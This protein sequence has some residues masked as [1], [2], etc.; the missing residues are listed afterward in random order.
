MEEYKLYT[1]VNNPFNYT[2]SK[3][4]LLFQ[5]SQNMDYRKSCFVDL[6]CGSGVVGVNMSH[7]FDKVLL[8]DGCKQ[9][10]SLL[11]YM[12]NTSTEQ[13]LTEIKMYI[14]RFHLSKDNKE[15]F[16]TAREVY[17]NGKKKEMLLYCLITHAFSYNVVF[18]SSGGFSVPSGAGRSYFNSSIK[19]KFK[20]FCEVMHANKDHFVFSSEQ[21]KSD[22]KF[23]ICCSNF[24]DCMVYAD[25]P[26]L[27]SDGSC[28]RS[29]GLRWTKEHDK[30]L[31]NLLDTIN[32]NGG[33]FAMSNAFEN[34]GN[35]NEE[36]KEWAEKYSV[37]HLSCDY[38]NC[39]HQRKNLG[40]TDEV[41]IKNY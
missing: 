19:N 9:M 2:A 41:L 17:N 3:D 34:N 27:T 24:N 30:N 6:F 39:H 13:M 35:V 40:S 5:L 33:S 32:E 23:N 28:S 36:L 20:E 29:Y 12:C 1:F 11:S 31:M 15:G 8:N 4:R 18:N 26:Y 10:V 22:T 38:T 21:I 14:S 37:V 25:P 16:L 7:S